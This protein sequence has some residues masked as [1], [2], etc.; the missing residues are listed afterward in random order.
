MGDMQA[1]GNY[2]DHLSLFEGE[3]AKLAAAG[4]LGAGRNGGDLLAHEGVHQGRFADVGA[5]DDG[6]KAGAERSSV[7]FSHEISIAQEYEL[8]TTFHF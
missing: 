8:K 1:G 6:Y 4:G 7:R 2:K 5:P 3:D